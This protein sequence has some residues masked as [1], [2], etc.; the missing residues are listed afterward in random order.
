MAVVLVEAANLEMK[1]FTL[2]FSL[3]L[4]MVLA[5]CDC[6]DGDVTGGFGPSCDDDGSTASAADGTG[7]LIVSDQ[8]NSSIRRFTGV[9]TLDSAQQTDLP[10]SG[11]LTQLARPGFLTTHPTSGDLIVPDEAAVAIFFFPNPLTVEGNTPP[12]RIL[13]GAATEMVAPVQAFV[14]S[15]T[16]ELYVLDKGGSQV[17]IYQN[18]STIE[19]AVAPDRRLT[20]NGTGVTSPNAFAFKVD[21]EQ[22]TILNSTELLTFEGYKTINGAPP[23][24]GRVTGQATTFANLSY[25]EYTSSGD[26]ILT[27]TGT[28]SILTF[29]GFVTDQTNEEPTRIVRGSNAGLT[30]PGQFAFSGDTIYVADA[31]RIAVFDSLSTKEG[32]PFPDRIFSGLN[33]VTTSLRGILFP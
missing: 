1:R 12:T 17:L 13:T 23:P 5:G 30:D 16:D 24:S 33:P 21:T 32:D 6:S 7:T 14:D 2:I 19:G 8:A 27:D 15:T 26:L 4:I 29:V 18:A 31:T 9:S 3:L 22:L 28:D 20:G 10:L 11:G 25:A